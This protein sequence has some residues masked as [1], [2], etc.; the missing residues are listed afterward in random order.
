MGVTDA[1]HGMT[2]VQVQVLDPGIIPYIGP[3][4]LNDIDIVDG[5]NVE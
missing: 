5:I 2:T 1:D 3:F 4:G